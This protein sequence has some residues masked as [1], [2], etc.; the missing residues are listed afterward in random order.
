MDD[1]VAPSY[2]PQER[3]L[4]ISMAIVSLAAIVSV[5]FFNLDGFEQGQELS[6][7]MVAQLSKLDGSVVLADGPIALSALEMHRHELTAVPTP[8]SSWPPHGPLLVYDG[9]HRMLQYY[10][11]ELRVDEGEWTLWW[12]RNYL[13]LP[14]FGAA[15]VELV[16]REGMV[17]LCPR[18]AEGGHRC[19]DASWMR[20]RQRTVTV[21]RER[22]TCIWAHPIEA[23]VLRYRFPEVVSTSGDGRVLWMET[24]LRDAAVGGGGGVDFRVTLDGESV[25]HRHQDRRG[26]QRVQVPSSN[27]P[28]ELTVEVLASRTGRRHTCFRFEFR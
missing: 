14:Y 11:M 27:R 4:A 6:A 17:R 18:D 20:M 25:T 24:A 8:L 9:N 10:S 19:G 3:R 23:Q 12:P 16:D 5:A 13:P 22:E 21:D 1:P 2:S 28:G 7:R 26:W 15:V